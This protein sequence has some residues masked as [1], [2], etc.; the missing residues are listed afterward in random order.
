MTILVVR[1]DKL[2]DF[3][4][5]LPTFYALKRHNP[6]HRVVACVAPLNREL[7]EACAFI[8][9]VVV[10]TGEG[11]F[12][13]AS[14]LRRVNA[15]VS[16]TLFSDTRVALAQFL[17][18]IPRRIAPATKLAQFFYTDRIVQ[19]RSRVEMAE[20]EYNLQLAEAL[21]PQLDPAFPQPLLR[22]PKEEVD[23]VYRGFCAK[24]GVGKPVVAFH[25]GFGGSSE[26]NWTLDEY[27]ELIRTL[28]YRRDIQI[29][30]TFGPD[31]AA[32][33]QA[34]VA[35]TKGLDVIFYTSQDGLVAF[36][37]LL[38]S[39][40][41]FVSTSTGTYHLAA[42][43][44]TPTMT[45]FGDSLFASVKRWKAVS[46]P[47]K[48]HPYMLSTDPSRRAEQFEQVKRELRE[49]VLEIERSNAGAAENAA[50]R[51]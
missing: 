28:Q 29:V 51:E 47:Q 18:R 2:G 39:F 24:Y 21:F 35:K 50:G 23:A 31:E 17:A 12:A 13:F 32:L 42:A 6:E 30:M 45:F 10:D 43:V 34:A 36:A 26:A 27:A 44:G 14:K 1:T 8:D 38:A 3:M 48:Q 33:R 19:R 40:K 9:E 46:A 16:V 4:T 25:P 20:Y 5:A 22:F 41:L 7:A 49:R 15:D 11:L 37:E